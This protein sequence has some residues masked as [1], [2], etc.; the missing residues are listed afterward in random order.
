MFVP[1]LCWIE[2]DTAGEC[3]AASVAAL[4]VA[5]EHAGRCTSVHQIDEILVPTPMTRTPLLLVIIGRRPRRLCRILGPVA[6]RRIYDIGAAVIVPI[7]IV[8]STADRYESNT[9]QKY[10]P[11]QYPKKV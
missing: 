4:P 6:R 10:D 3:P 1:N 8:V 11:A 2:A 5:I 7:V 9:Q